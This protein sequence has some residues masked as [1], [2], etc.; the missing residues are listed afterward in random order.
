MVEERAEGGRVNGNA[1]RDNGGSSGGTWL[2]DCGEATQLSVQKTTSIKP[3]KITK[4]FLTHCH[5]DHSFGLPGLLCL[6]GTDRDHDSPPVEIY[7]P[8]G[9]RMWLRVAIRYSVS[10]VVPPYRVHELMDVP[11]APEWVEGHRK[12]GRFYYQWRSSR[13]DDDD[14]Y[15]NAND[16]NDEND[17]DVG[18][19]RG[20]ATR[21]NTAVGGSGKAR[22]RWGMQGLAGGDPVSWISRAPM[23]NLEVSFFKLGIHVSLKFMHT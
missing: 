13:G 22:K 17:G 12:N 14:I 3:G 6:M 8:E 18:R 9:L 20:K 21:G 16:D 5:G 11:M 19:S 2:F 4:I 23:M 7:G 10:R 15:D 1:D